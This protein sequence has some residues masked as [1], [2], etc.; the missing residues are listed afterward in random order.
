MQLLVPDARPLRTLCRL[1]RR[2]WRV[3]PNARSG[4]GFR[5]VLRPWI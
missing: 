4:L 3:A 5:N 2:F 1:C